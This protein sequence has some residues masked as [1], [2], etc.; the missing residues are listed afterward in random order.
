MR[1]TLARILYIALALI[2]FISVLQAARSGEPANTPQWVNEIDSWFIRQKA[3]WYMTGTQNSTFSFDGRQAFL[4]MA[5]GGLAIVDLRDQTVRSII[6][7]SMLLGHDGAQPDAVAASSTGL[8]A[9]AFPIRHEILLIDQG[10][11]RVVERI[12]TPFPPLALR[13]ST[14]GR[15]LFIGSQKDTHTWSSIYSVQRREYTLSRITPMI[16]DMSRDDRYIYIYDEELNSLRWITAESQQTIRNFSLSAISPAGEPYTM[17]VLRDHRIAIGFRSSVVISDRYLRQIELTHI[18]PQNTGA[19][20]FIEPGHDNRFLIFGRRGAL[21][22]LSLVDNLSHTLQIPA[23]AGSVGVYPKGN[24]IMFSDPASKS[25]RIV[26]V[27]IPSR[28][29]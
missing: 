16:C 14:L 28:R 15:Y 6:D 24:Y 1:Y 3:P 26:S 12:K 29:M 19:V 11:M 8:I 22:I 21:H 17:K 23:N 13:F 18:A 2:L 27:E 25:T 10:R 5:D 20:S 7:F 9:A 4:S